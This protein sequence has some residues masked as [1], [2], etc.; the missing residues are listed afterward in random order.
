MNV[1]VIDDDTVASSFLAMQLKML[2]QVPHLASGGRAGLDLLAQASM[3]LIPQPYF[4]K[5]LL[6]AGFANHVAVKRLGFAVEPASNVQPVLDVGPAVL[7][8]R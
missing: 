4:L 1:L 7:H 2:G 6:S 8:P 5:E 3:A